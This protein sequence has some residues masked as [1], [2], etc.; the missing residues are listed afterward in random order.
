MDNTI[1][2]LVTMNIDQQLEVLRLA[3]ENNDKETALS[4][5]ETIE[6]NF[7]EVKK[8]TNRGEC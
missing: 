6:S 2:V 5:L 4:V 1:A 8:F 3:I 7:E